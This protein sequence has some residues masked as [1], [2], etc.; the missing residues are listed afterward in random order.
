[1]YK[2]STELPPSASRRSRWAGWAR[3]SWTAVRTAPREAIIWMVGLAAMAAADPTAPPLLDLCLFD[4]LGVSFC[5]GCGLGHSIAWFARGEIAASFQ[6][7]PLGVPAVGL[8]LYRIV[9][10]IRRP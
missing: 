9:H 6:A 7:H 2:L 4:A 10:L 1:M 8:L 3:R 5:P